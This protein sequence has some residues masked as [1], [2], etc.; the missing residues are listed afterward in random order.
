MVFVV[1]EKRFFSSN[2]QLVLNQEIIEDQKK[3]NLTHKK[4]AY[5]KAVAISYTHLPPCAWTGS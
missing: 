1:Y 2:G 3:K 5:L 4:G